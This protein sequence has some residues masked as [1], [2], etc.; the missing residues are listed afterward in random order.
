MWVALQALYS[1]AF[2][3]ATVNSQH[4]QHFQLIVGAAQLSLEADTSE[5]KEESIRAKEYIIAYKKK[6]EAEADE[7]KET[8]EDDDEPQDDFEDTQD[9]AYLTA[10]GIRCSH[11]PCPA[12]GCIMPSPTGC[13]EEQVGEP[14][15]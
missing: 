4:N 7:F 1:E 3:L 13:I 15:S 14:W 5:Q 10:T 8:Q 12:S 9:E 2:R 11:V 6:E